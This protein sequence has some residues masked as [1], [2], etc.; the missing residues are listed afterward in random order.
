MKTPKN[1]VPTLWIFAIGAAYV[2]HRY[3]KKR[4]T[5]VAPARS[6]RPTA[7]TVPTIGR[8]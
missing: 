7:P 8:M 6:T 3:R 2:V 5:E 4:R 1:Q